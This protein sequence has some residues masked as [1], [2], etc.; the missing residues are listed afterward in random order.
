MDPLAELFL[1]VQVS[2]DRSGN[3]WLA[4]YGF[5][6]IHDHPPYRFNIPFVFTEGIKKRMFLLSG[7]G[8]FMSTGARRQKNAGII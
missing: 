5:N 1:K 4:F 8:T 2:D 6:L 7:A 3:H